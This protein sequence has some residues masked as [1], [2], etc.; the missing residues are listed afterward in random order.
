MKL[1][2]TFF[3]GIIIALT[4]LVTQVFVGVI[5]DIFFDIPITIQYSLDDT[6]LHVLILMTIAATIEESLRYIVIK[7]NIIL[8][9]KANMHD[10]IIQGVLFGTGFFGFEIM[11]LVFNQPLSSISLISILPVL[12]IHIT[13]SI[14]LLYTAKR[15]Q[16][17]S[18]DMPYI[19]IAIIFHICSN[20]FLFYLLRLQ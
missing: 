16:T 14:F 18:Y 12:I 4:S 13:L 8:Y 19:F 2:W 15:K 9:T 5:S 11:L 3:L 7:K 6:I 10:I 1:L 17:L 20:F